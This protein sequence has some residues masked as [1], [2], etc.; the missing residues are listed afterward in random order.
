MPRI[1]PHMPL[2]LAEAAFE[3]FVTHGFSKG[4]L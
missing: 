4:Y 2:K 1:A 3:K